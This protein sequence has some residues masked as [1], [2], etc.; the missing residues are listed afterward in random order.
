M[1]TCD[2]NGWL[3]K[4]AGSESVPKNIDF[5]GFIPWDEKKHML[6]AG[7]SSHPHGFFGSEKCGDSGY[8][9]L[10]PT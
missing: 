9:L 7:S 3:V 1:A 4:N 8:D 10:H 5:V 2:K 6:N